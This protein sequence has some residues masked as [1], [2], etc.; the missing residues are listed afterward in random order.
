M[1]YAVGGTEARES[2]ARVAAPPA[3]DLPEVLRIGETMAMPTTR[4]R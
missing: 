4:R 1:T 3:A 2:A